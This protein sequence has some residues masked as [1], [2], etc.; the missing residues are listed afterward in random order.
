MSDLKD[1]MKNG[2]N[3]AADTTK[4]VA[5]KV[6]DKTKDAARATG[7]AMKKAGEKVKDSG[8]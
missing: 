5:G 7:D 8:K 2:I 6:I 4:E 3:T 1:K